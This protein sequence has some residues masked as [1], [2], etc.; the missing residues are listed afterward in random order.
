MMKI[1]FL[2]LVLGVLSGVAF[3]V[4]KF[5]NDWAEVMKG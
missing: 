5:A 4:V 1:L 2:S 3:M